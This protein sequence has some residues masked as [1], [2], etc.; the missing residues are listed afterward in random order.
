MNNFFCLID[1]VYS[2]IY[3]AVKQKQKNEKKELN[4]LCIVFFGAVNNLM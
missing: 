1:T 4:R 2:N 3:L